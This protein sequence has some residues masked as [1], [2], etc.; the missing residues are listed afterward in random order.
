MAID[1]PCSGQPIYEFYNVKNMDFDIYPAPLATE[2]LEELPRE[3]S[4]KQYPV[5]DSI[6]YQIG[7][8]ADTMA[9]QTFRYSDNVCDALAEMW[10]YLKKVEL[11]LNA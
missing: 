10:L 7:H 3:V 9:L 1:S 2:I 6:R 8:N 11:T 4:I 5:S